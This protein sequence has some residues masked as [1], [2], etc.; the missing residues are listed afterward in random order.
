MG[1]SDNCKKTQEGRAEMEV[2]DGPCSP[3]SLAR[4]PLTP[5]VGNS[6]KVQFTFHMVQPLKSDNSK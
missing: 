4:P 1:R 6:F 2:G 3:S 5:S